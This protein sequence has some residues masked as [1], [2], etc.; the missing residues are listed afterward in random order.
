[1]KEAPE[2]NKPAIEETLQSIDTTLKRIEEIL[3]DKLK[4]QTISI[5]AP[6]VKCQ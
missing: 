3:L 6:R 5:K 1:M 4:T 2:V